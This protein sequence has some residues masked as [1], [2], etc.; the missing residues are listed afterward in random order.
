MVRE[1]EFAGKMGDVD[2]FWND[3]DGEGENSAGRDVWCEYK[4]FGGC[5]GKIF[6]ETKN[7]GKHRYHDLKGAGQ[8]NSVPH[9]FF[10]RRFARFDRALESRGFSWEKVEPLFHAE[11]RN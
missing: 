4:G 9:G 8:S 3:R 11:F 6:H 1:G 5:S 7:N 2:L 10:S